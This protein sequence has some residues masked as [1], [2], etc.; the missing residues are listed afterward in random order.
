MKKIFTGELATIIIMMST[1]SLA[2]AI[3]QPIM[4]LYL[5]SIAIVPSLIG[6]MLATG[7][8]GM[9]FGESSGGWLADK[10]GLKF[11]LIIGTFICA[12][13]VLSFVFVRS[14][15]NIFLIFLFWGVVRAA[16]FGPARG[17]IGNA[18]SLSN[19]ATLIAVYM[20]S[21]SVARSL[22]SLASGYIADNLGYNW[23]FYV[24]VA[25]SILA[26]VL[27]LIGLR[28]TPMWKSAR[29][30]PLSESD[31]I[32]SKIQVPFARPPVNYRP[33]VIQCMVTALFLLAVGVNT[34]LPLLA[35]QV[36][37]V[38]ATQVGLIYTAGSLVNTVMLIPMGRLADRRDKKQLMILGMLLSAAALAG[39]G[40]TT[41]YPLLIVLVILTNL[42]FAVF[43]PAAV[44]LLSN[45]VPAYWQ[46]TAMG[47][48]GAA[49][50][51]GIIIG[52]GAG[53]FLWS[54]GGPV[55]LYSIGSAA[56]VIGAIICLGFVRE[57]PNRQGV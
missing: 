27:V 16:I 55:A 41:S 31:P 43:T 13:L 37:G 57:K 25:V 40:F 34:F 11:P 5:T 8:V 23:D 22:G 15:S 21:Q 6:L 56:A 45:T 47:I 24:S 3:L 51:I 33:F 2:M 26:G 53:G 35:T 46:G 14:A 50:D 18:A 1:A 42:S 48:Y 17:Y 29:D 32:S 36:V 49:E 10:V 44:A 54:A 28:K 12:P 38:D 7:M 39:L 30:R 9:V 52:S 19:K 4:P 20:T